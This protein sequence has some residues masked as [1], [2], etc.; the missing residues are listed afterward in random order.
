[1]KNKRLPKES[2]LKGE[3]CF[4]KS[5]CVAIL[6]LVHLKA[7]RRVTERVTHWATVQPHSERLTRYTA[8]WAAHCFAQWGLLWKR[9]DHSAIQASYGHW[10]LS[11]R[12]YPNASLFHLGCSRAIHSLWKAPVS[13]LNRHR[14]T[15]V[16]LRTGA[17]RRRRSSSLLRRTPI[18]RSFSFADV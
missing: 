2:P 9:R 8:E 11:V 16:S 13:A 12:C 1:M 6:D 15:S 10:I 18:L 14:L 17:E 7:F 4:K 3:D 5:G